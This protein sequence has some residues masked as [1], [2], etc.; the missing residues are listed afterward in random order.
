MF[1]QRANKQRISYN[2]PMAW[3]KDKIFWQIAAVAALVKFGL[4]MYLYFFG[5]LGEQTLVFPDSLTYVYPAQTLLAYGH[6]WEAV[7]AVPLLM[8]TP[9]YPV[10]LAL[11]QLVTGNMTWAV[12]A[13]Q[14]L[15]SL[16]LLLPVYLTTR[17]L[18]NP[19]AARWAAGFCAASVLYFSLA[20]A[21][22]TETL[23]VFLLAW[24]VFFAV[25]WIETPRARDLFAAAILLAAAVY[26]RPVV[27]Y[28]M[29]VMIG[30]LFARAYQK[31][32]RPLLAQSFCWFAL[33][34]LIF[35]GAW[36]VRNYAQTGYGGF[37][38]V[39]AYNLYIW[40]EDFVARQSNLTV[41]QAH[42]KLLALLP[43]DFN[44]WPAKEQVKTYKRLAAPLLKQSWKDK[45]I[46]WPLWAAKTLL[47]TNHVH[48]TRLLLGRADE[49]DNT[50]NQTAAL[51]RPWLSSWAE[52][53]L[54]L[55]ALAQVTAVVLLGGWGI[56]LLIKTRPAAA[57]FFVIYCGYF[58]AIGSGFFGAYARLRAPFEF[59]LCITAGMA[60]HTY[61]ARRKNGCN[62]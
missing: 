62:R 61:L 18:S 19:Q 6:L 22:L 45:L 15:L 49:P 51:P 53:L 57:L 7:S 13:A 56:I 47:G 33:P 27:Y 55:C 3:Y 39:G 9:G 40:N 41:A 8:R 58:W 2:I 23:C 4:G 10:F 25:R 17:R 36:Q 29:P 14:N 26:V 48:L 21:V 54:F 35:I 44:T 43:D 1:F 11:V 5:P 59:V 50:L 34:L 28:F 12:A 24:F 31:K 42:Q 20:F 32:S 52:R 60:V 37:T 38:S 30:G 46:R 16:L